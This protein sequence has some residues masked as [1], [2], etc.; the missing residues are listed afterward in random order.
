MRQAALDSV[1]IAAE[2]LLKQ[3]GNDQDE[4]VRGRHGGPDGLC[5]HRREK[6]KRMNTVRE[7]FDDLHSRPS[8]YVEEHT[9]TQKWTWDCAQYCVFIVQTGELESFAV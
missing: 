1:K 6:S 9:C 3:A 5:V 8:L 7:P 2:E 4:A